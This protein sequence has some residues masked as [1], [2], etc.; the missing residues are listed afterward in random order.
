MD[1]VKADD[2]DAIAN[3]IN[4]D[5]LHDSSVDMISHAQDVNVLLPQCK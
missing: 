3:E 5:E 4:I 1:F 2:N